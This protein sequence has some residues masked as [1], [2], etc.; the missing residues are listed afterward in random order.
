LVPFVELLRDVDCGPMLDG[1]W[2]WRSPFCDVS[3]DASVEPVLAPFDA[4]GTP[5]DEPFD[6]EPR[7]DE[8]FD[9]LGID[10]PGELGI[11]EPDAAF[12]ADD[13]TGAPEGGPLT[14][15]ADAPLTGAAP[16]GKPP[17][18]PG[19]WYPPPPLVGDGPAPPAL[20]DCGTALVGAST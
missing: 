7:D 19:G 14:G 6:D 13:E 2:P 15:A 16:T 17:T 10:E 9:A 11:D 12:G 4:R 3:V 1:A 18:A 5:D 20:G 8:P